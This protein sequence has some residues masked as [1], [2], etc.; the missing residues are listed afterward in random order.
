[1]SCDFSVYD[2]DQ[3]TQACDL[4]LSQFRRSQI[5]LGV[6]SAINN[7]SIDLYQSLID[8]MQLRCLDDAVGVQLDIIGRI[9][10][11]S[12]ELENYGTKNWF[13]YDTA[14]VGYDQGI[15]YISG[16]PVG[17]NLLASDFTYR[18][19]IYARIFKNHVKYGSVINISIRK[20]GLS[21]ISLVVP[22]N[23]PQYIVQNLTKVE[24]TPTTDRVYFLPIPSTG[25][26]VD[27][28][29][30][31]PNAFTYDGL[32]PDEGYDQGHYAV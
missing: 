18:Q 5:L 6:Q 24:D 7:Q 27:V 31:P 26:I 2:K 9:V 17:G 28:I 23:T 1:M 14:D 20:E 30:R 16:A 19:L 11:Q 32:L 29:F 13:S 4:T 15:Y 22:S 12:R 25:R 3:V 10:G 8:A 21:D